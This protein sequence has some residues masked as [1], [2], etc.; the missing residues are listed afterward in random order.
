MKIKLSK[1][2]DQ[3]P[4]QYFISQVSAYTN[5]FVFLTLIF[6]RVQVYPLKSG[7]SRFAYKLVMQQI[8]HITQTRENTFLPLRWQPKF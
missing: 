7:G 5:K 4:L 6:L 3:L 2:F 1:H 8:L